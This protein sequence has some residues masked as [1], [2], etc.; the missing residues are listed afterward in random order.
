MF[1]K[2]R[3]KLTI[4]YL[5][6][7]MVISIFFSL[8][9]FFGAT[10]EFDRVIRFE[11]FRLQHP[12]QVEIYIQ[13][14]VWD[15]DTLPL[16]SHP[17]PQLIQATKIRMMEELA[18]INVLILILSSFA[19][20]FLAGRTLRPIKDMVDEQNRFIT[21][22]SHELNTPLTSLKTS[23]EVNLRDKNFNEKKARI[24]LQS[25]L[26]DV[27][28]LQTLSDELIKLN[29]Y[30]KVNGNITFGKVNLTDTINK[31]LEKVNKQARVKKI[32][33]NLK[34]PKV[35]VNG[36][37]KSLTELFVILLD[38]SVKYSKN[39]KEVNV[40]G[41]KLDSRIEIMVEDQG[42]GIAKEDLPFI[43]ERFYRSEK[44]R[45]KTN[46]QGYGLGLSI[47]KRVVNL[48]NGNIVVESELNK[49]TKFTV[50]LNIV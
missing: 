2:A 36:D 38:N 41:K 35:F 8:V 24:L 25:N 39:N 49:G 47:A 9:I 45:T 40:I 20:Y 34:L 37:A 7:I 15:M 28:S 29:Q 12:D 22:A 17:N 3:L 42:L 10:R 32:K 1:E 16:P 13:R 33:I 30:Q 14:P 21:D 43:F 46:Y 50:T 18:L 48:H 11:D 23:I 4:W 27:N 44:S 5:F 6:L 31:A 19:G 26:E